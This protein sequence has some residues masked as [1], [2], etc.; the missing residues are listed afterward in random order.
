[1]RI[2][3][4]R[5]V[6][7]KTDFPSVGLCFIRTYPYTLYIFRVQSSNVTSYCKPLHEHMQPDGSTTVRELRT[8]LH[9]GGDS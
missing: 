9:C 8:G 6:R 2:G 5:V 4:G 1:M 3:N 7:S